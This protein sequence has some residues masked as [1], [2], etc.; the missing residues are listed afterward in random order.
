[1]KKDNLGTFINEKKNTCLLIIQDLLDPRAYTRAQTIIM[2][3]RHCAAFMGT[4]YTYVY[5]FFFF[6]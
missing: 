6:L 2:Y 5:Y 4:Y 3:D 1:M